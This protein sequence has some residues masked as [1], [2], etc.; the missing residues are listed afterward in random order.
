[1][2]IYKQIVI[3]YQKKLTAAQDYF[4]KFLAASFTFFRKSP[5]EFSFSGL[6]RISVPVFFRVLFGVASKHS[7][8]YF[9]V[10]RTKFK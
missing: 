8:R 9:S 6:E 4:I 1:M 10:Y 7:S 2:A 3:N 5:S